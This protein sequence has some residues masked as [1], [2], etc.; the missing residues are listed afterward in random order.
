MR[1]S[2]FSELVDKVVLT[3]FEDE[4]TIQTEV[5]SWLN[6][7]L[8]RIAREDLSTFETRQT[9]STTASKYDYDLDTYLPDY[10]K[11]ITISSD[12]QL[13]DFQ[14]IKRVDYQLYNQAESDLDTGSPEIAYIFEGNLYLYPIPDKA[15]SIA[16][17][18]YYL[19]EEMSDDD[20]YCPIP[21]ERD[22]LL[23]KFAKAMYD[24]REKD[25][26]D[27][28]QRMMEFES[29]LQKWLIDD[30]E[31]CEDTADFFTLERQ[32]KEDWRRK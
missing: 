25:L 31:Q 22:Y 13:I 12:Q 5:K 29:E 15:Y 3:D 7:A 4:A 2:K 27:Y 8:M 32:Y 6:E 28:R 18:Y 9:F 19:P 26:E 23:V 14:N 1:Q 11:M 30:F 20:D 21:R 16:V 24:L 10:R 17:R